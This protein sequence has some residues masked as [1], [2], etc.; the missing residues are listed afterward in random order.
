VKWFRQELIERF[1]VK[2]S[3][4]DQST[5]AIENPLVREHEKPRLE[6]S[7]FRIELLDRPKDIKKDLLDCIF[8]VRAIAQDAS[9]YSEQAWAV[10]FEQHRQSVRVPALQLLDQCFV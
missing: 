2:K 3:L 7:F 9:C 4:R 5:T 10:P 8:G 1:G 6:L